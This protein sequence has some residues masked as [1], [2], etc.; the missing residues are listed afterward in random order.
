[1]AIDVMVGESKRR[2][3]ARKPSRSAA[4]FES[5]DGV[6]FKGHYRMAATIQ[7][8]VLRRYHYAFGGAIASVA[9]FAMRDLTAVL[10]AIFISSPVAGLRPIR[11]LCF[12]LTSLPSPGSSAVRVCSIAI[13]ASNDYCTTHDCDGSQGGLGRV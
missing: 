1:M 10:A 11:S 6:A 7:T 5:M 9:A 8:V 3:S 12:A 4:D 13:S 2:A